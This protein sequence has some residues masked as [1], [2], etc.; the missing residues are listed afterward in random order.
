MLVAL[1]VA[2]SAY[3]SALS[4][5]RHNT[6]RTHASDLGQ[7]DQALWNTLH[8][9][10]L[11]DTRQ[12]VDSSTAHQAP[13]LTD[14][15]EPIFAAVSLSYLVY[16]G[17]EA[18]LVLQ[19]VVIALGALPIF[20]IARRRLKSEWGALAF[21][22]I[23]LLFP[24]L[25][26]ANLAEFHADTLAP[27][28]L[29][30]A[31]NYA[32]ERAWK[33]FA[34]F[35]FLALT[36]K[37]QIPLL[38][39]AVAVW[40]AVR[41]MDRGPT[42][43]DGRPQ[44]KDER[45]PTTDDRRPR[46]TYHREASQ[47]DA[48]RITFYVSRFTFTLPIIPLI[49]T[50]ISLLWF[51]VALFIIVPHFSPAGSSVYIGRYPCAS[52]AIKNPL[53]AIPDLVGCVLMPDKIAYV[54]G[55][56]ASTGFIALLDPI[57]LLIGSPAVLMNV[58]S[59]F[60]GQYSGAYYYS[61]TVA[62]FFV[63]A[64]IGGAGTASDWLARRWHWAHARASVILPVLL[65]ALAYHAQAGYAPFGGEFFWPPTTPHQQLLARLTS[66]IPREVPV[67][68]TSPLF[69]HLSHRR[70]LYRF[71]Q[72]IQDAEYILLDV[73]QVTT[74]PI[75]F[76]LNYLKAL[77]QGFGIR[78]A[79]DGYILLQRGLPN[80]E[81]PDAFYDA[82]RTHAAPQYPV[83]IDFEDKF[84]FLG[85]DVRQD[86]WQRVYLRTYWTPLPG[87]DNNNYALFPFYVGD[88]GRPSEELAMPDLLIHF[89]YP[90][91]RWKPGEV[92]I[93][94]TLPMEVG[95]RAKLGLGV[96]FG[97]TWDQPERR[98]APHTDAPV[99]GDWVPLGELIRRGKRYEVVR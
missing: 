22:G 31:Y 15:V 58:L 74:L 68:T 12:D 26:A 84:R 90:T 29:L 57:A 48:S 47:W 20:W 17:V 40:A 75:D 54:I 7:M 56:L 16:D 71:P 67:S 50:V 72:T 95:A 97:A 46:I 34:L 64:A 94:D 51:A 42:T 24:A 8:G 2:Y 39:A 44:T 52:Q 55:L 6:F 38:V 62:P 69:P 37:E 41:A 86:D 9:H 92:V 11:E 30:F 27:A 32:E 1:I 79:V 76:R 73:S 81:L 10:F 59:S 5:Q 36:V 78:D 98:L 65:L 35:S 85:Y 88:D 49:V 45:R 25:Q 63:L 70:F 14:H 80:K 96:F 43:A 83:A 91:M 4:I 19:S 53:T 3:F 21:A 99:S 60:P 33:R 13:R 23:Y 61:A 89:W 66:Q 77:E 87:L 82:F 93:A 28:P 18:I